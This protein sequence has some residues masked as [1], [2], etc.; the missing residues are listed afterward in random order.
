MIENESNYSICR[1]SQDPLTTSPVQGAVDGFVLI[2]QQ[3]LN[4]MLHRW[5]VRN[6]NF[7]KTK[8]KHSCVALHCGLWYQLNVGFMLSYVHVI[9]S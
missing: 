9:Y 2:T 1:T 4:H 3:S 7:L 8:K 6:R 5:I